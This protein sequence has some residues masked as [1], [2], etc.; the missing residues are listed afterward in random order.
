MKSKLDLRIPFYYPEL[1]HSQ[2]LLVADLV[3]RFV[4][5]IIHTGISFLYLI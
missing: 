1:Q 3:C 5:V 4:Y 2:D